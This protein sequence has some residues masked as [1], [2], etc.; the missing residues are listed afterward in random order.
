MKTK[1]LTQYVLE[2]FRRS[3]AHGKTRAARYSQEPLQQL[4]RLGGRPKES[5]NSIGRK[6]NA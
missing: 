2:F 1:H 3:G 6:E 5:G 4:G